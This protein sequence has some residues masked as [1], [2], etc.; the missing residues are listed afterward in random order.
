VAK[1]APLDFIVPRSGT[2]AL[3]FTV[4][5]LADA[6]HPN[7]ARLY[8][9]FMLSDAQA[10]IEHANEYALRVGAKP[11]AGMPDLHDVKILPYDIAAALR[12]QTKLIAWW[13]QVTGIH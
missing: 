6:P 2:I 11:P 13:Q 4:A 3:P 5:E 9:D 10:I 8:V 7:A 1:G 12:D